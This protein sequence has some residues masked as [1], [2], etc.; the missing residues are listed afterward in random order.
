M[1][2]TVEKRFRLRSELSFKGYFHS[3][4]QRSSA[5]KHSLS[6][7]LQVARSGWLTLALKRWKECPNIVAAMSLHRVLTSVFRT[8]SLRLGFISLSRNVSLILGGTSLVRIVSSSLMRRHLYRWSEAVDSSLALESRVRAAL[9]R[10]SKQTELAG[11]ERDK[12]FVARSKRLA[13]QRWARNVWLAERRRRRREALRDVADRHLENGDERKAR[14]AISCWV[15]FAKERVR[16]AH[17]LDVAESM[18]DSRRAEKTV[19]R[20]RDVAKSRLEKRRKRL[21]AAVFLKSSI[22]K[23]GFWLWKSEVRA[24]SAVVASAQ[25]VEEK[26]FVLGSGA[27]DREGEEGM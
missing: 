15:A 12:Q 9:R 4:K 17:L 21:L 3:W 6:S 26:L 23:K 7:L 14:G 24:Q 19:R 1:L 27:N 8:S 22:L 18:H 16:R 20:W 13:L 2:R 5:V 25:V 10:W 11:Q